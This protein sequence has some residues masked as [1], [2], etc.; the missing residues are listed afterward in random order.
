MD[1]ARTHVAA[2]RQRRSRLRGGP[3]RRR[4]RG[5]PGQGL[6]RRARIRHQGPKM[7]RPAGLP[8]RRHGVA[9]ARSRIR[10]TR[11]AARPS[12]DMSRRRTTSRSSTFPGRPQ[13]RCSRNEEWRQVAATPLR[14]A[15]RRHGR[16]RRA[17]LAHRR[18]S[19]RMGWRPPGASSTT[20]AI[21]DLDACDSVAHALPPR[22]RRGLPG[23]AGGHRWR[24]RRRRG[25]IRLLS[26]VYVLRDDEWVALRRLN[27]P[28]WAAAA[29]VVEDKIVVVG[30][31]NDSQLV[32][33]TEVLTAAVDRRDAMPDGARPPRR[34]VRRRYVYAVGG[35]RLSA[36]ANSARSS[37]TTLRRTAGRTR[38][39]ADDHRRCGRAYVAGRIV[40]VGG[41]G[42]TT[43][44]NAVQAYDVRMQ[45]WS[46]FAGSPRRVMGSPLRRSRRSLFAIGGA[47]AAGH[48]QS[49]RDA[50]VLE[51]E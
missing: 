48:F 33:G 37:A 41:E 45:Q 16:S 39:D 12:P 18:A 17:D 24:P 20:A 43:V 47:A 42:T 46:R 4:R 5:G 22:R 15:V 3:H 8:T 7:V 10:Y 6:R 23:R 49:T 27:H 1:P 30:G 26:R 35:R 50:N 51:F 21:N 38:P 28:R 34:G 19:A 11:S 29:A 9:V 36:G 44:S 40:A 2:G 31:R 14:R 13:H 32:H 25:C